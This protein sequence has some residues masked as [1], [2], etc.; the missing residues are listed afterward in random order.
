LKNQ[1]KSDIY[2]QIPARYQRI[3]AFISIYQRF[4]WVGKRAGYPAKSIFS[5][6]RNLGFLGIAQQCQSNKQNK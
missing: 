4:I 5:P 2:Q 6:M 1:S 3:S